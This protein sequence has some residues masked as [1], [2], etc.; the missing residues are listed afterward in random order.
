M[1]GVVWN[2]DRDEIVFDVKHIITEALAL[3][4]TK[5]NVVSI[6]SRVHDPLRFIASAV[7]PLK[8]FFQELCESR[9]RWDEGY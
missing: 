4:H 8:I 6:V 2:V 5:K 3:R 7:I 1:L 9:L